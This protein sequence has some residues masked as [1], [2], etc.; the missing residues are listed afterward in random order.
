MYA[1]QNCFICRTSDSTVSE[2][3]GIEPRTLGSIEPRTNWDRTQDNLG[4]NP[5]HW[6]RTQDMMEPN[7]G[8]FFTPIPPSL[9]ISAM[10]HFCHVC[11]YVNPFYNYR[12]GMQ[13]LPAKLWAR[14]TGQEGGHC[15]PGRH[16]WGAAA[17][18]WDSQAHQPGL[19]FTKTDQR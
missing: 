2:D 18:R 19:G 11:P 1:I 4:S 8:Q 15:P 17:G 6:D 5:G 14:R 3:A 9:L 12:G 16:V 7:S 10:S 13:V